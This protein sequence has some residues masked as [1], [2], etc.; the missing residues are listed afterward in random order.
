MRAFQFSPHVHF[1]D[2]QGPIGGRVELL[3]GDVLVSPFSSPDY[4]EETRTDSWTMLDFE[5]GDGPL[6]VSA[7]GWAVLTSGTPTSDALECRRRTYGI[8]RLCTGDHS[9]QVPF[10]KSPCGLL[11]LRLSL[12]TCSFLWV[13]ERCRIW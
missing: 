9:H 8:S 6:C 12:G 7:R 11:C 13:L 4:A 2:E 10:R 5:R 3:D 1:V